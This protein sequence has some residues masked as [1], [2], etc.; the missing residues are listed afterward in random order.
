MDLVYDVAHNIAKFE[1]HD[2]GGGVRSRSASIARGRRRAFPP[3]HPEIPEP[4][5]GI[6]QPVIIPGSMGTASW[7]LAGQP[8]SMAQSFGTTCHGAGPD[9]EPDRRR[10][11]R[12]RPSDRP[13]A[14]RPRHHRPRPGPQGPRRGAAGR[15]QGR[16]PG[17]RGRRQGRH[18]ARRS[19]GCGRSASSR[20][21]GV[22]LVLARPEHCSRTTSGW[23]CRW[24]RNRNRNRNKSEC[25]TA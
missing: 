25:S 23:G 10:Q 9:D 13:G 15:L 20:G 6:G 14:R 4:Y 11:A 24:G 7:V 1:E 21:S 5:R 18:L 17:R 2:V 12:R 8:G 22:R 19:P 3:G 16:R